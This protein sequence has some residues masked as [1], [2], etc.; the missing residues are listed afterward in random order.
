MNLSTIWSIKS[1][2]KAIMAEAIRTMIADFTT[3]FFVGH[4]V[5]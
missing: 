5:L 3:C 1:I 4:D 2:I